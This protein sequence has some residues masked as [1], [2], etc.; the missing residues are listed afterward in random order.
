MEIINP[1]VLHFGITPK[2][3]FKPHESRPWN[4]IIANVFYRAGIIEKWGT[5]TINIIEWCKE[6]RNPPPEWIIR[7]GSVIL[8][9]KPS[10]EKINNSLCPCFFWVE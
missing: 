6:N 10:P 4:P 8:I 3:L 2:T 7:S 9:F 5:G 1:G